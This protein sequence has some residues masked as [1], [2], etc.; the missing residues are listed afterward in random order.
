M[1]L[2]LADRGF[3]IKPYYD[4]DHGLMEIVRIYLISY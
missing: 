4:F 1:P 2:S 3:M